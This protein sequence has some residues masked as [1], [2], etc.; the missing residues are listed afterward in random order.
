MMIT[1]FNSKKMRNRKK[2]VIVTD[3]TEFEPYGL[4]GSYDSLGF[5]IPRNNSLIDIF[6]TSDIFLVQI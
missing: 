1:E 4:A 3:P 6:G 5:F 2:N